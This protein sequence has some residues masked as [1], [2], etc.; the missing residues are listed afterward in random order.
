MYAIGDPEDE[1][2]IRS[3][4]FSRDNVIAVAV[5]NKL[6]IVSISE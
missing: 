3:L 4:S 1:F 2:W 5:K 6:I